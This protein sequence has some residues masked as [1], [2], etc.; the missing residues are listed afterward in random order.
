MNPYY[1]GYCVA[2][3]MIVVALIIAIVAEVKV[4]NTVNNYK[5]TLSSIDLTGAELAERLAKEN[6][7]LIKVNQIK[8]K[9]TD[10]YNPKDKSLNL[11]EGVYS[12]KSI[13]AQSIVAHEFGHAL[14]DKEEYAPLK[15]RQ[16][17][18]AVSNIY[19]KFFMPLLIIGILLEIFVP[20][21]GAV[22]IYLSVAFY[23]ISVIVNLATVKV[24]YDAS[25]RAKKLLLAMGCGSDQEKSITDKTLDAAALTYVGSLLISVAYFLRFLFILLSIF[26]DK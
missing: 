7:V 9:L 8:G 19:S 2:G 3:V 24:E 15:I 1:I 10:H 16:M 4:N 5:D 22:V 13:V 17:A 18:I 12:S 20:I 6:D 26:G 23:G 11:S 14:Q 21:A 25:A